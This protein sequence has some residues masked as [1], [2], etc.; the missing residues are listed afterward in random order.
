MVSIPLLSLSVL[1]V[2]AFAFGEPQ[3]PLWPTT[4]S[5][6]QD[7]N[8]L[9]DALRKTRSGNEL[10]QS[11]TGEADAY[12]AAVFT[13]LGDLGAVSAA[14]Y[15]TLGHP[16]FSHYSVRIKQSSF[17][18]GSVRAYTGYIDKE[19]R[20]IFFYFFE[21]RDNPEK[22]DVI[23]WTNGGPGCSSAT[24]L[25]MELGPCRV[26]TPNN[27]TY[28]PYSW[29][30]HANVFFVDQPIGVGFSYAEHGEFVDNTLDAAKD[31]AAF[32]AIFFEHFPKLKGRAFHMAGE[33]YGGRYIPVFAAEVYDQN[34][35]LEKAGIVP[36]NL[37]S[38]MIGN[39][40][41]NWPVMITSYYEMQCQNI[42]VPPI[43]DAST[44]VQMK[45]SLS[46]CETSF[47]KGCEDSFNYL[48]CLAAS[49]FCLNELYVPMIATGY[50]PYDI[51]KPCDGR[52]DETLCYPRMA[53]VD[54]FLNREDIR[55]T[56]GVDA[57]VQNFSSCNDNVEIAFAQNPGEMFPTQYYIE[58]LLERGVRTLIYVGATDW[59][60]NWI[61]N[62]RMTLAVEWTGQDAFAAQPLREW[63]V[64]GAPAGL[65]RSSGI[66]TF[67]TI[68]GAGHLAPHDKPK[69]CL[70]LMKRWLAR[71]DL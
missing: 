43:Q 51:S 33:S 40:I 52:Y 2:V 67:A 55:R 42:S 3:P 70:E 54:A 4:K 8:R 29:N 19:A 10:D 56:L 24:G 59:F 38:V 57:A 63:H 17:C 25:F 47:K 37:S 68:F 1:V 6:A 35:R 41:T 22:D 26:N 34:A 30:E 36:I 21:S 61:G 49:L 16:L 9:F 64:D 12:N 48:D 11:V 27:V 32:V 31:I 28:N 62:E 7:Q 18:D 23:F 66:F 14:G 5:S 50:N 53:V 15:T 44:C 69:E 65:T 71:Q 58:A 60:G 39:G 20:H 45:Y 46:R 13:A